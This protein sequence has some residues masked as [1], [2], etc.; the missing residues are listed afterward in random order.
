MKRERQHFDKEFKLMAVKLCNMG[1]QPKEVA[2]EL[3][4]KVDL[5]RRWKRENNDSG[6]NSFPGK[7]KPILTDEQKEIQ[8]LTKELKEA[9]LESDILKKAVSIFSKSDNK[10]TIS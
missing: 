8:R 2:K 9:R 6:P 3:G 5:I 7:G 10:F 4:V 1:K